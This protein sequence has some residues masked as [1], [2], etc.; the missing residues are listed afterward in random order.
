MSNTN[1]PVAHP[2]SN[3]DVPLEQ[4]QREWIEEQRH[5][6]QKHDK[7]I[8]IIIA[9]VIVAV[10]VIAVA[11]GTTLYLRHQA[12][13]KAQQAAAYAAAAPLTPLQIADKCPG[14]EHANEKELYTS[15]VTGVDD[16]G[17]MNCVLQYANIPNGPQEDI[18][19][20]IRSGENVDKTFDYRGW[21]YNFSYQHINDVTLATLTIEK[22]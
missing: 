20:S 7:N 17:T 2:T 13:V 3:N 5:R 18:A 11:V 9:A 19:K 10:I 4:M 6:Q 21:K 16:G 15:Q 22:Q 1:D 14:V 12:E 8:R